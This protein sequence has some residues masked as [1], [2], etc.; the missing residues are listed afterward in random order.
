MDY[1]LLSGFP[2][3]APAVTVRH[4]LFALLPKRMIMRNYSF[5]AIIVSK[6]SA[7]FEKWTIYPCKAFISCIL[8]AFG[9]FSALNG[10][11]TA[12]RF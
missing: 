12:L 8:K 1:N 7:I 2:Q 10:G 6:I 3:Q 11:F 9:H 5:R 4:F